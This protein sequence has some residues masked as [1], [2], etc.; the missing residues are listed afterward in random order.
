MACAEAVGLRVDEQCDSSAISSLPQYTFMAWNSAS[1]AQLPFGYGDQ[2]PAF[3]TWRGGVDKQ[4]VDLMRPLFDKGLRPE[5]LSSTLLELHSKRYTRDFIRREQDLSRK[6]QLQPQLVADQFSS[7]S[8]PSKYGGLVPSGKYLQFVYKRYSATISDYLSK[9]V[10]KR[11]AR[12]FHW[13]ASYKECKH[14]GRYEGESLFKCLITG[15]NEVGDIRVQFHAV[16][17]GHDQMEQALAAFLQT[18]EQYGQPPVELLATDKPAEDKAFFLRALPSLQSKQLEL[19]S[20]YS[21]S[22]ET[23]AA[24]S[25]LATT[26]PSCTAPASDSFKVLSRK[27]EINAQVD[28]LRNQ[29][30]AEPDEH[31]VIAIDCE[32]D[33]IKTRRGLVIGSSKVAIIQLGFQLHALDVIK[34]IEIYFRLLVLPDLTRRCS[35]DDTIPIH[36]VVDVMPPHGSIAVL[37]T[38]SAI[39]RIEENREWKPSVGFTPRSVHP[40]DLRRP[41]QRV[42]I[43]KVLAP[44]LIVPGVKFQGKSACLKD[45]GEPPFDVVLPFAMLKTHVHQPSGEDQE[46]TVAPTSMACDSDP[47]PVAQNLTRDPCDGPAPTNTPEECLN[48]DGDNFTDGDFVDGALDDDD[49][50][51]NTEEIALCR[52]ANA[53]VVGA[54][55]AQS[56]GDGDTN[57]N[58]LCDNLDPPPTHIAEV[59]STVVGDAFHFMDRPKVPVHH[60]FK[61]AYFVAL[62]EAWFAWEP[63]ALDKVKAILKSNGASDAEIEAKM[64]YD[65]KWFRERVPRVVPPP[66][67]HYWRVRAV[68]MLFGPQIDTKTGVPLFNTRNWGRANNV[69]KEILAG[70]AADIPSYEYYYHRLDARGELACDSLGIPLID[71]NRGTNDT[72]CVHKQLVTT[73]G[74]WHI[75]IEMSDCLMAE[76][77]HRYNQSVSERRRLGFPKL[78]HNDTWLIDQLQ[79]LVEHNHNVSWFPDWSNANDF[80]TTPESFGTVPIHSPQL[81]EALE[82]IQLPKPPKLTGDQQ[83]LCKVMRTP[84]PLLPV[85]GSKEQGLFERLILKHGNASVNFEVMAIDWCQHVDCLD[86]FPKLPVYLRTYF[87]Q[88]QKNQRIRDA[89]RKR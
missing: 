23:T 31:R 71:C 26:L 66:P 69:L 6:R 42:T 68:F 2:F 52:A 87:T 75:G 56:S 83:Y 20:Y 36:S 28:A 57:F 79:M 73:F 58:F 85:V 74:T 12:R 81:Q 1:L 24:S 16:T 29:L 33:T 84:L 32:W 63:V 53:A 9:E 37:A 4:I 48:E 49:T 61:K 19:D 10:K 50:Q 72:E 88:W 64:Y 78:G 21:S 44:S 7:F 46:A 86:I 38:V 65:V 55:V 3:F 77:R 39:A 13:D 47:T 67:Q 60:E 25:G 22:K 76:R 8:D 35:A 82:A 5:A 30:I 51:L 14:L 11:G 15:T 59:Y 89:V 41:S 40:A 45:F 18:V 17:D 54:C 80:V 43:I 70:H 27:G 62:M 34:P